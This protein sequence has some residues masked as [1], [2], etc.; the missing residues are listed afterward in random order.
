[1]VGPSRQGGGPGGGVASQL[2]S[3]PA[4]SARNRYWKAIHFPSFVGVES[5]KF[6]TVE[7][8]PVQ[9]VFEIRL[10]LFSVPCTRQKAYIP[11]LTSS[12]LSLFFQLKPPVALGMHGGHG[13]AAPPTVVPSSPSLIEASSWPNETQEMLDL[14]SEIL[15]QSKHGIFLIFIWKQP[16]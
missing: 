11:W 9:L 4:Q 13:E 3:C 12:S 6:M 5:D 14:D 8:C 15:I 2:A 16:R 7:P 1:M 10:I